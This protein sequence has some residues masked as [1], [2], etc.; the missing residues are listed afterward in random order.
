VAVVA[1]AAAMEVLSAA[2]ALTDFLV[3]TVQHI[4]P[5]EYRYVNP[6]RAT[7]IFMDQIVLISGS[8]R[9]SL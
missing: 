5:Y 3:A 8:H 2:H 6:T 1:I 9:N 7:S 4:Y